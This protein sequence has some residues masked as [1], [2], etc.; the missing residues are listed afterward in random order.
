MARHRSLT[1][2]V[3]MLGFALVLTT[4]ILHPST[5]AA[6][7][8][9]LVV[10]ASEVSSTYGSGFKTLSSRPMRAS[11]LAGTTVRTKRAAVALM[12]GFV[13]GYA[14]SYYRTP[15][16]RSGTATL[17]KVGVSV[18]TSGVSLYKSAAY[19]RAALEVTMQDKASILALLRKEH[20]TSAHVDWLDGLGE[21]AIM[22]S[23]SVTIRAFTPGAKPSK[24]QVVAYIFSRGK[25]IATLSVAGYAPVSQG[26]ALALAKRADDRI[27]HAG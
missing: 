4:P 8:K 19:P 11:D 1:T 18:V 15:P 12:Q 21:R 16:T 26:Q 17:V 6:S 20:A 25:F 13:G 24:T 23:D 22:I 9:P 2:Q 3:S 5:A 14:S 10:Q 7:L 27:Q